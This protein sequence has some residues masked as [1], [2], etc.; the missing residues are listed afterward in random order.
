MNK[1]TFLFCFIFLASLS[2]LAQSKAYLDIGNVKALVN[3][4]GLLFQD[5]TNQ[6]GSYEVPKGSGINSIKSTAFW[7]TSMDTINNLIQYN[8]GFDAFGTMGNLNSIQTGPVDIVHQKK[9]TS[10]QFRR[11]WKI[12]KSEI[13]FHIQNWSSPSYT[14][15]ASIMDWPGNGNANTAKI[16][17]PFKDLDG[18]SIYEPQMGEYPLIEGDQAIYV[19]ANNFN[20][21]LPDTIY[22]Y[23]RGDTS[24]PWVFTDS[25]IY[26]TQSLTQIE[27]HLMVYAYANQPEEISNAVFIKAKLHNRSNSSKND[28]ANFRF[29]VLSYFDLGFS[30]DNYLGT[31]TSRNMYYCYNG[32]NYDESTINNLGYGS[33]LGVQGLKFLDQNIASTMR[34]PV[35][36]NAVSGYYEFPFHVY[37]YQK[38]NW[39]NGVPLSYGGSGYYYELSCGDSSKN[40]NFIFPG[41]PTLTGDTSQWT[42]LNPCFGDSSKAITPGDRRM[43]G[44]PDLP[45]NFLHKSSMEFNFAYVFARD[46]SSNIG[47]VTALQ[48]AADT[49]QA[50]FNKKTNGIQK[51]LKSRTEFT[52]YPNP[53]NNWVQ[54][55][56]KSKNFEIEVLDMKGSVLYRKTN[57]LQIDV[58]NF[59]SGIYFIRLIEENQI[60]TKKLVIAK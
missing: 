60:Q 42:E 46:S 15:P 32:D 48:I 3:S 59:H 20:D 45:R 5:E 21:N 53:A 9:D 14:I 29:S 49:V 17:A 24:K 34:V 2:S 22:D 36:H 44:S 26:G 30:R 58:S 41:D 7:M 51:V 50:F 33:N 23:I 35:N 43:I 40:P 19:I 55:S 57:S 11:L 38:N 47:S 6:M 1:L 54:I 18:D 4:N 37:N 31:D 12:N 27:M 56:T 25:T 10:S 28:Y 16:L 13:D 39:L 8:Y 52:I